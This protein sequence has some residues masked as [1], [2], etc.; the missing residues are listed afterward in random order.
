M[1]APE[2]KLFGDDLDEYIQRLEKYQDYLEAQNKG[3]REAIETTITGIEWRIEN[4]SE[5]L[6]KSDY[7]HY[8]NLEKLL[9]Q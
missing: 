9:K 6:D 4:E 2:R 5:T 7:E 8:N 3:L 1:I